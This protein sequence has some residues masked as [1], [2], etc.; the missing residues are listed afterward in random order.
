MRRG[1]EPAALVAGRLLQGIG[2]AAMVPQVLALIQA[3]FPAAERPRALTAFGVNAGLSTIAGQALGGILLAA[4]PLELGWR[5]IFVVQIP[6]AL[7]AVLA[8]RRVLPASRAEVPPAL[9]PSGTVLL[10]LAV[11]LV[12]APLIGGREA[13]WPLWSWLC[14]P[15]AVLA[16]GAF[17]IVQRRLARRGGAPLLEPELLAGGAFVAGLV[18]TLAFYAELGS[19]FLVVTLFLQDGLGLAPLA[20]GLTF[21]PLG[22]GFA[23]SSLLARRIAPALGGPAVLTGGVTLVVVTLL[24]AVAEVASAGTALS[25]EAWV[26]VMLLVGAGNG[27]ALPTL[28]GVVLAGVPGRL[29]GTASGVLMTA[30]QLG[31]ALGVAAVGAVYFAALSGAGPAGA[32]VRAL[33]ADALLAALTLVLTLRLRRPA[34]KRPARGAAARL[35]RPAR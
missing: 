28:L 27:L 6:F 34:T 8:S 18:V 23:L 5:A 14:G 3:L 25:A 26:P 29:A 4:D 17:Q 13:G 30:Q 22:V 9:D 1:T 20:A 19:F 2:A 33:A 10:A 12:L 32:T 7:A 31:T 11:G 15:A 16:L 21:A 24:A 35:P